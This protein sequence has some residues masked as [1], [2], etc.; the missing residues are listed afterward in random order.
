MIQKEEGAK[1]LS[2]VIEHLP[3]MPKT[4]GSIPSTMNTRNLNYSGDRDGRSWNK[5]SPEQIVHKTLSKKN[6]PSQK[7][8]SGVAQ[9]RP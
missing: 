8:A 7:R 3:N 5:I 9:G 6:Q 4:L 1:R 2:S